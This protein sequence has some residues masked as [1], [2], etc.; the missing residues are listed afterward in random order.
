MGKRRRILVAAL[1]LAVLGALPPESFSRS[2]P[3]PVYES[4]QLSDWLKVYDW[5]KRMPTP[6]ER[7]AADKAVRH[8]GTNAIPSLLQMLHSR[9][10]A[11]NQEAGMAFSVLGQQAKGA[12]RPLMAIVRE[13][14]SAESRLNAV[15][16][17]G[18]IGPEVEASVPLLLTLA[19]ADASQEREGIIVAG[20][21]NGQ[22]RPVLN[23]SWA[24]TCALGQIHARP[25][26]V[27][28]PLMRMLSDELSLTRIQAANALGNFGANAKP[29][30]PRLT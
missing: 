3:E 25:E 28:A 22:P 8:F 29:A 12:V 2:E 13:N 23:C 18:F 15:G 30:I 24:A 19:T 5:K 27:V 26:L 11:L 10:P 1:V 9:D 4:K 6:E 16:A 14:V 17:L 20:Y 21:T 7:F